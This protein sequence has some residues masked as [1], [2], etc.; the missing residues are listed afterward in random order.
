MTQSEGGAPIPQ[1]QSSHLQGERTKDKDASP[2]RQA[3]THTHT[4]HTHQGKCMHALT[5]T[6]TQTHTVEYNILFVIFKYGFK[7][8]YAENDVGRL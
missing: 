2:H 6:P 3:K 5:H 8:D 1:N 7:R 4:E